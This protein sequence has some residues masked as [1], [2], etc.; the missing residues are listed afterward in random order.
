MAVVVSE[1]VLHKLDSEDDVIGG[2]GGAVVESKILA[3]SDA[4]FAGVG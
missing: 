4:P 1:G 2:E 3:E